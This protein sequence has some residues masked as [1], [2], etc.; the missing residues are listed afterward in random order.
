[1]RYPNGTRIHFEITGKVYSQPHLSGDK[2]IY[3]WMV[4]ADDGTAHYPYL[5]EDNT[6]VL[7]APK[8]KP[9]TETPQAGDIYQ[10]GDA[11]Y[12]I[13]ESFGSLRAYRTDKYESS[14]VEEFLMLRPRLVRRRNRSKAAA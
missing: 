7:P 12:A 14:G 10:V 3:T 4:V 8:P 11:E 2:R 9:P 6:K 1:M 5:H 13:M